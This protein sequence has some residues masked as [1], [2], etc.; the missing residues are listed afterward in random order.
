MY[1]ELMTDPKEKSAEKPQPKT[2]RYY[3]ALLLL[4]ALI[5]VLPL[6]LKGASCGHDFDFHIQNW[7]EVA[8][9]WRHGIL[10][11]RWAFTAAWDAGE[12]RLLFYP[13]ISWHLG[14]IL[15]LILPWTWTPIVFTWIAL[16]LSGLT[17]YRLAR[18]W[19]SPATSF[20]AACVY[21]ANPYMLFTA[22][23][24]T[25]YAELLAAAWMPLLLSSLL[26]K[27]ISLGRIAIAVALLWLTNAPAAVVGCYSIVILGLIRIAQQRSDRTPIRSTLL[28]VLRT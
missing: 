8:S 3:P 1:G 25:A 26:R 14:A 4:A 11:P 24:R 12:P 22:Y 9:Q 27:Q 28:D 23:E 20:F 18:H 16:S 6:I 21:L 10:L 17:L 13:P 7:M 5:A 19:C 15:G 2:A